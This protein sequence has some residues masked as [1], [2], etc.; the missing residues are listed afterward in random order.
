MSD[1]IE[2]L[3]ARIKT[4]TTLE[5]FKLEADDKEVI[6]LLLNSFKRKYIPV[7]YPEILEIK[8]LINEDNPITEGNFNTI[9]YVNVLLENIRNRDKE[10][11]ETTETTE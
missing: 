8:K 2:N 11:A 10:K 4:W 7:V 3:C 6:T 9:K 1:K 5:D